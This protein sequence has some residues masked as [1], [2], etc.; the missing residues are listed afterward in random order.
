M[1]SIPLPSFSTRSPAKWMRV[2]TI[3]L[4]EYKKA[5]DMAPHQRGTHMHVADVYWHTGRW[6]SA[7]AEFKAELA[8]D[9]N[10]CVAYWKLGD[11]T[12]EA[13]GSYEDAIS[14]LNQSIDRCPSIMEA[15]VGRARRH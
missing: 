4:D 11:A 1:K 7:Q 12:I 6:E 5:I 14:E 2:P 3:M 8:N 10:N 9:S 13:H 15:R